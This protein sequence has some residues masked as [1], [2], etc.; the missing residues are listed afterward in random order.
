MTDRLDGVR[1]REYPRPGPGIFLNSASWGLIP[2]SS[3]EEVADLTLR[4]TRAGGFEEAELGRIQRRA[5]AAVGAL[6]AVPPDEVALVPN[7]SYGVNLAAALVASGRP[8]A[9]VLSQGEFP[10]N[11][12]PWKALEPAGFRVDVVASDEAGL[13][14]EDELLRRL[15]REDVRALAVSAVQFSTGFRMDLA[16]LGA[17]C[18]ARGILFCVDA[19]QAL[20]AVPLEPAPL[21]IDLL[22]SGGQKWLC[23]P[24]GSGFAWIPRRHHARFDP[25]MVSWLSMEGATRFDDMLHYSLDWLGD[26]RRF[27]LGTLGIQ[28]YLGLARSVEVL[29]ECGSAAVRRHL[30]S[31]HAPVVAWIRERGDVRALTPLEEG[32]RAGILSFVPPRLDR[33]CR[34]LEEAGV[35]FARRE[36]AVRLS[37]HFYNTVDEMTEVVAVMD[38]ALDRG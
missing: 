35:V 10:A 37:P 9:I 14:R 19:I 16:R 28:D 18:S 8:G 13:P 25:P 29:L 30:L 34:A 20:G 32:R 6:L 38:R 36:G 4:R 3:A 24:W 12:L 15:D 2:R 22:A 26:A 17:A 5:R 7:T 1:A 27:E 31:L 23:S 21:N 11:V 33:V